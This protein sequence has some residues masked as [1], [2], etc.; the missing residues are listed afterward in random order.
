L[1][2]AGH[3]KNQWINVEEIAFGQS[4]I[5]GDAPAAE[6]DLGGHIRHTILLKSERQWSDLIAFLSGIVLS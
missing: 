3:I 1:K 6:T 2:N 5:L 4:K